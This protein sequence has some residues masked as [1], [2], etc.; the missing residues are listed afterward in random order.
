MTPGYEPPHNVSTNHAMLEA[1][2]HNNCNLY[3]NLLPNQ[4]NTMFVVEATNLGVKRF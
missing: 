2:R 4:A 3:S 1:I